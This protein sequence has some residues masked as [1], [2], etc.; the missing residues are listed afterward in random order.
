M[1]ST[2]SSAVTAVVDKVKM[3]AHPEVSVSFAAGSG[4]IIGIAI[5]N[6]V[7]PEWGAVLKG[8]E[9]HITL[10]V[11]SIAGFLTRRAAK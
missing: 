4:T 2:T 10:F 8:V 9:A 5:L 1:P 7:S 11:G 3:T 6:H